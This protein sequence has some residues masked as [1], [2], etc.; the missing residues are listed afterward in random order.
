MNVEMEPAI[1][2]RDIETIDEIHAVEELQKAV[3]GIPDIEVV[4]YTQLAAAINSGGTLI[5]AFD[6]D[7]AIGF[8]YG[9][10][11]HERGRPVHHSHMLAVKPQ[12][13]SYDLGFRLKHAQRERV[14]K[15]GVELMTWTFDP[16][17]GM[18]A[19]FNF[20][21]LGVLAD[22]YYPDFYGPNAASFLHQTGTDRL[23]VTWPLSRLEAI[24]KQR[25]ISRDEHPE[26]PALLKCDEAERPIAEDFETK[27][28]RERVSI[29]IPADINR[30]MEKERS[31]AIEWR[32]ASRD[33]FVK[34]LNAGF[35]VEDFIRGEGEG[36]PGRYILSRGMVSIGW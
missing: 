14:L 30:L 15:Q 17:Q 29:E 35:I 13:R 18:N 12:Y 34:A 19:H 3:W 33:A 11:G 9:F 23:W 31:L 8:A 21:K 20:A 27:L 5:G 28:I 4:P 6:G 16:L 26:V 1:E 36:S 22:T 32:A 25:V 24:G 7:E 10:A 2:I